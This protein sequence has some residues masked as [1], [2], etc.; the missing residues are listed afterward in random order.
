MFT[1]HPWPGQAFGGYLLYGPG[2]SRHDEHL[3][4]V[5]ESAG[6]APDDADR[7]AAAVFTYVLGNAPA[8]PPWWR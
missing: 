5:Y 2:K 8:R 6:F 1:R 3:L 7:A 4:A